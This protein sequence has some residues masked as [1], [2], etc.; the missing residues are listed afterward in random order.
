M[1]GRRRVDG[2]QSGA[3]WCREVQRG[4]ERC[5]PDTSGILNLSAAA[6][7]SSAGVMCLVPSCAT[8]VTS[9]PLRKPPPESSAN[10]PGSKGT[11]A[12]ERVGLCSVLKTFRMA[13]SL[14]TTATSMSASERGGS[15]GVGAP[16]ICVPLRMTSSRLRRV[17]AKQRQRMRARWSDGDRKMAA[18]SG[19]R[20]HFIPQSS[21][22]PTTP[23]ALA[24]PIQRTVTCLGL[25]SPHV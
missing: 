15:C 2:G 22:R 17:A 6:D 1:E 8:S 24:A 11:L 4:A 16:S 9:L 25:S 21:P 14:S 12:H 13:G 7:A 18:A 3:E 23:M 10:V 19:S 5:V 20:S